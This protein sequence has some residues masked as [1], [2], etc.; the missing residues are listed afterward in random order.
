MCAVCGFCGHNGS[1]CVFTNL[2]GKPGSLNH[3]VCQCGFGTQYRVKI[4]II[5]LAFAK[6]LFQNC[7]PIVNLPQ[8]LSTL[9]P[10]PSRVN[11]LGAFDLC[12]W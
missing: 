9:P 5:V 8:N 10:N 7:L 4:C 3:H 2:F 12:A 6:N 1:W 11:K